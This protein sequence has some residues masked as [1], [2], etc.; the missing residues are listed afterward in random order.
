MAYLT[1]IFDE[2]VVELIKNGAA[3]FM[4]SDTIYGLSCRALDEHTVEKLRAIKEREQ[5]KPFIVLI[6]DVSQLDK[7][8]ATS[9]PKKLVRYWPGPLSIVLDAPRAPNWL[10][11]KGGTLAVRLPADER[12]CQLIAKTGPIV[13]TS[14]NL[15]G[16]P[17]ITDPATARK[18]FG[19]RLDFY[20]DSGELNGRPSTIVRLNGEVKILRQGAVKIEL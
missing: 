20:V 9:P 13:S 2:K 10:T 7:L 15:T 14:A 5:H 12:L 6:S 11:E 17:A 19:D 3:G 8:S 18:I 1:K 16:Q 4:P